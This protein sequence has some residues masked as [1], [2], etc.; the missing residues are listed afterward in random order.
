MNEPRHITSPIKCARKIGMEF[1]PTA[2]FRTQSIE[3]E[4]RNILNCIVPMHLH[5]H[6]IQ[7]TVGPLVSWLT[8]YCSFPIELQPNELITD[9][10]ILFAA[11]KRIKPKEK[12]YLRRAPA[13][14][15]KIK[16]RQNTTQA[17]ERKKERKSNTVP[18]LWVRI[19][20]GAKH[21]LL[22]NM[23]SVPC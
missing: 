5:A 12:C 21:T 19:F 22:Y 8:Q 7:H 17:D 13:Q 14:Q 3:Y 6:N 10:V 11:G 2:L 9:T 20:V 1:T 15:T 4:V 16:K 23:Y 18:A